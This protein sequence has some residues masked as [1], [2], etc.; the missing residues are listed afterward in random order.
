MRGG[1]ARTGATNAAASLEV[2]NTQWKFKEKYFISGG[3]AVKTAFMEKRG[4]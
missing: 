3:S 1:G 2:V 4:W